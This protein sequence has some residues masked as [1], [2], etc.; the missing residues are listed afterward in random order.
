MS[1]Q[2]IN[3]LTRP[4]PGRREQQ[5]CSNLQEYEPNTKAGDS[6]SFG[7]NFCLILRDHAGFA[8]KVR[9]AA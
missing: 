1:R 6:Q 5:G 4:G 8:R 3:G 7:L 9:E 2:A